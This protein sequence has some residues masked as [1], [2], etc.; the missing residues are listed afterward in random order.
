MQ[1][2]HFPLRINSMGETI[3]SDCWHWKPLPL[4]DYDLV[5]LLRGKACYSDGKS[6]WPVSAGSCMLFHR[7][8]QY[9]GV[10]EMDDP[11]SMMFI[12]FDC[13]DK[14]GQPTD[15][16]PSLQLP[17]HFR[18]ERF[19]FI[20]SLARCVLE[21]NRATHRQHDNH[22]AHVWL[23]ALWLELLRQVRKPRWLGPER[24]QA[25]QVEA[26]C[27]AV[28]SRIGEPWRLTTIAARMG[29]SA[30]HAGRLFRKYQGVAPGEFVIRARME[31]AQALLSSSSQ[32]ISQIAEMLGFCDV[33]AFSRQFRQ[34][35]GI[36][37]KQYRA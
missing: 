33:Y 26:I 15:L 2:K 3:P 25:E 24:E 21:T 27:N 29:C 4:R 6:S 28:R 11:V 23:H 18:V 36:S 22:A 30:E 10:Q 7:G 16:L 20:Q 5:L 8:G 14:K 37:P 9:S 12:H 1:A 13:L 34:R 31:A 17:L 32:S 19:D 35:V